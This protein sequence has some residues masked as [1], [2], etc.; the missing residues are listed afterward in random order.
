MDALEEENPQ[1]LNQ[2]VALL[3]DGKF[4]WETHPCQRIRLMRGCAT[5]HMYNVEPRTDVKV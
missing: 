3:S 4:L 2:G 5:E 1:N